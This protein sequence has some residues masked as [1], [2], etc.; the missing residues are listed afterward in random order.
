MRGLARIHPRPRHSTLNWDLTLLLQKLS[1]KPFEPLSICPPH[2]LAWKMAFLVAITSVRW[3]REVHGL[4]HDPPY[5]RMHAEGVLLFLD[6]SFFPK[7]AFS[8]HLQAKIHPTTFYPNPTTAEE[9]RLHTLDVCRVLLFYLNKTK[10][11]CCSVH[12]SVA[13]VVLKKCH[14]SHLKGS[15]GGLQR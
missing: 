14:S 9:H 5:L 13:Y 15:P 11:Y 8:F 3:I 12:L 1:G 2:L 4:H 6:I 7:V 10:D